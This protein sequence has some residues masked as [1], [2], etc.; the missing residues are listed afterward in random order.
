MLYPELRDIVSPHLEPPALPPDP[1]NCAVEF[2]ALIGPRGGTLAEPFGFTVVT[3]SFLAASPEPVW[4]RGLLV[5]N[6]FSWQTVAVAVA[7][8]LAQCASADWDGISSELLR[9]LRREAGR[10]GQHTPG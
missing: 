4:G 1:D 9:N 7:Q 8:L 5:V 6:T 10:N 3:P 2:T